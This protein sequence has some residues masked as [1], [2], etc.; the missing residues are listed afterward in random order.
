MKSQRWIGSLVALGLAAVALG[1]TS[2]YNPSRTIEDQGINVRSWGSGSI[3]ETDEAAFEGST[4]V[5]ISSR[6]FFQGGILVYQ[7][8]VDLATL[9]SDKNN[10]LDVTLYIPGSVTTGGGG[11]G[12]GDEGPG[13]G[14]P[15]AGG[16]GSAGGS[17]GGP[18]PGIGGPPPGFG[19]PG[20]GGFRPGGAGQQVPISV[21]Q[22]RVV[23]TTSDGKKSEAY[24]SLDSTVA[25]PRGWRRVGVPLQAISGFENTN[26]QVVSIAF[27]VDAVATFYIGELQVLN[28]STPIYGEPNVRELNLALGDEVSLW[29]MGFAGSSILEYDWTFIDS[30]G[31]EVTATGQVVRRRFRVPGD[32]TI[33]LTIRD[34]FGL[35]EPYST[36]ITVV[37]N[38]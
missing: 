27:S 3:A 8:P 23:I 29:A 5:R 15:T 9:F 12:G 2:I 18:P 6:N 13:A 35:K 10:L 11:F 21:E 22:L 34:A 37:V 33:R 36:D 4:S 20:F 1:Q 25:D 7:D 30:Q 28:D 19:G 24:L 31:V 38:P 17:P 14:G 16:V 26:K 32:Y